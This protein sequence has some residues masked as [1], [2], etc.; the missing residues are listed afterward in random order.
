MLSTRYSSA[1]NVVH[2]LEHYA[3]IA[4]FSNETMTSRVIVSR[5]SFKRVSFLEIGMT[6]LFMQMSQKGKLHELIFHL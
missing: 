2:A 1:K 6:K 4:A 5:C 3:T